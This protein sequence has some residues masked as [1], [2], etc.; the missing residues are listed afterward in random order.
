MDRYWDRH[1]QERARQG[2]ND[3]IKPVCSL[4]EE[5]P[6][7]DGEFWA[8]RT[9]RVRATAGIRMAWIQRGELRHDRYRLSLINP[10]A[11]S[12]ISCRLS[13]STVRRSK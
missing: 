12:L 1:R 5:A 9:R 3:T 10:T 6:D 2:L 13:E 4:A 11:G 7:N 8:G